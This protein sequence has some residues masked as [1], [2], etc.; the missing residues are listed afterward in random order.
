[1]KLAALIGA[2]A[3]LAWQFPLARVGLVSAGIT[4]M[5]MV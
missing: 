4:Y 5:A 3:F 1:M 2:A